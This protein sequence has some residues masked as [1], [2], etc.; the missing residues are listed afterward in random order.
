MHSST[1]V[2]R[3]MS[4]DDFDAYLAMKSDPDD[5][6]WAGFAVPPHREHL[7]RWI[8]EELAQRQALFL[9]AVLPENAMVGYALLRLAAGDMGEVEIS[10]GVAAAHRGRRLGQ[11]IVTL[12]ADE[13][14]RRWPD[15]KRVVCWVAE[16][17]AASTRSVTNGGYEAT[18]V[19]RLATFALP[20]RHEKS[21]RKFV[22]T[23]EGS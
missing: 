6:R 14:R 9:A 2:L 15:V 21:M 12:A 7:V 8:E 1:I 16:D 3:P 5:V 23:L 17:N 4:M 10:Y 18:D 20:S 11:A 19:T 13:A 22:R